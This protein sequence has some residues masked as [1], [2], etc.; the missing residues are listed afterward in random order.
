MVRTFAGALLSLVVVAS[1]AACAP[2]GQGEES[3]SDEIVAA[4][5]GNELPWEVTSEQGE[6]VLPDLF[7][8]E[9]SQ[10]EQIM[11]LG[12]DGHVFIDRL[13]YPTVGNPNLY[14][15]S[16]AKDSLMVVT[17]FEDSLLAHLHPA[18][19]GTEPGTRLGRVHF[20]DTDA[21]GVRVMLVSR[22]ARSGATDAS[23]A[24][25]AKAGVYPLHPSRVLKHE[26]APD[27]PAAFKQRSTYRFLFRKDEM[28]AVP[29]GL[30]DLR[31]EVRSGAQ[32]RA[33]EYQYNAV[34]VF[35]Q[36]SDEYP[37][38]SITD[39]QVSVGAYYSTLTATKFDEIVKHLNSPS[40]HE[41]VKKAPF[42]VFNGDLHQGGASVGLSQTFVAPNYAN[43][44]K[45]IVDLLKE[46][47]LPI[48]LVPGNHDGYASIGHA[49]GPAKAAEWLQGITLQTVV[50]GTTERPWPGFEWSAY[51]AFLDKTAADGAY[52]GYAKD[53]YSG[54]FVRTVGNTF[55]SWKE[56]PR[57]DRNYIL[58]DGAYHWQKTYGPRNFSWRFGRQR[59]IGIDTYRLRQH[60]RMS[61]S[62][63][64]TNYGGGMDQVEM[65][66]LDREVSRADA[67][68]NDT[69]LLS[70]HDARGGH[71][72]GQDHGYYFP[73]RM[74]DGVQQVMMDGLARIAITPALCMLP[75][76]MLDASTLYGCQHE[77]HHGWMAPEEQFDCAPADRTARGCKPGTLVN[78][79]TQLLDRINASTSVRTYLLGHVH[80]NSYETLTAGD[81]LVPGKALARAG[82]APREL[83]YLELVSSS[84]ATKATFKGEKFH[85][86]GLLYVKPSGTSDVPQINGA[87]Y[88]KNDGGDVSTLHE[89]TFDRSRSVLRRDPANPVSSL[90][91]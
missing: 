26:V 43:E 59:Y 39:T 65:E 6:S 88:F 11:P 50:E 36:T 67:E 56:V 87:T 91:N 7:Y 23:V 66:W 72:G 53:I 3:Q 58:Y 8:A 80:R 84:S 4:A 48:F 27:M 31:I 34:R 28:A 68:K 71:E 79:G 85:G 83:V 61:W 16:D 5:F 41:G 81:E 13:L 14:D 49:P 1:G 29:A 15:R 54:S 60:A 82:E 30:Y 42:I 44:A 40:V 75:T 78:S 9:A 12:I 57:S 70:H 17:R 21:D 45:V 32:L 19:E 62:M 38:V 55:A 37:V 24:V 73:L 51:Q 20:D 35:D 63:Y 25:G 86:F 69:I 46:L 2:S 33:H 10:N 77:G 90:F 22:A 47:P 52:G 76:W 18:L 89:A 64:A 74:Y